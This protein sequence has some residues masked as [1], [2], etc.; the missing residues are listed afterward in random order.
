MVAKPPPRDFERGEAAA[1]AGSPGEPR[2]TDDMLGMFERTP[3]FVGRYADLR[4][5]IDD[6]V[7]RYADDVRNARFPG[8]RE[9][10][11]LRRA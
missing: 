5:V 6:A 9:T 7:V 3:K 10:Y 11:R 2:R 8:E 1:A 4:T